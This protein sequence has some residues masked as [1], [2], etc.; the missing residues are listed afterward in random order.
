[1]ILC[2]CPFTCTWYLCHLRRYELE[3]SHVAL[4]VVQALITGLVSVIG[5]H[6]SAYY[7]HQ[8]E[9]PRRQSR[10]RLWPCVALWPC[11]F[12]SDSDCIELVRLRL[13]RL[14]YYMF[15]E[16]YRPTLISAVQL[17]TFFQSFPRLSL[18]DFWLTCNCVAYM[19]ND[20]CRFLLS[21]NFFTHNC[22]H[23]KHTFYT[24]NNDK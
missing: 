11:T 19:D 13:S 24:T 20:N 16:G 18:A 5:W 10:R 12:C 6:V 23:N 7:P 9:E 3:L 15:L 8:W 2:I 17:Q 14:H 4:W 21:I 1:V 22:L